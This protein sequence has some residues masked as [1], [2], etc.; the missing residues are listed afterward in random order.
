MSNNIKGRLE[1]L[2]RDAGP[3]HHEAIRERD[4]PEWP[5]WYAEH[6]QESLSAALGVPLSKSEL[7]YQLV[8]LERRRR[9]EDPETDW[10]SYYAEELLER[11][12]SGEFA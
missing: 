5:L 7:V 1:A 12:D 11:R 9:V 8:D 2:L 10:P 4:D 6:L 3:A